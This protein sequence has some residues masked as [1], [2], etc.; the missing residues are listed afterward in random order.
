MVGRNSVGTAALNYST[1]Y[2]VLYINMSEKLETPPGLL[3]TYNLRTFQC[4]PISNRGFIESNVTLLGEGHIYLI[5]LQIY[6]F[7]F[8]T[9]SFIDYSLS[10]FYYHP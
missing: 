6:V 7:G 2:Y 5:A 3:G 1:V 4:H 8:L 9:L 10:E